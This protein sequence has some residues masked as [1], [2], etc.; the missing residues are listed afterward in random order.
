MFIAEPD[1]QDAL[2]PKLEERFGKTIYVAGTLRNFLE[3]MDSRVSKGQGLRFAL[4]RR[5][6]KPEQVIAFGDEENDIPMFEAA[7]FSA[8]PSSAKETVR[9]RA[10]LVIGPNTEDGVAAFLEEFFGL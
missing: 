2:R 6:L 5:G 9:A 8:A 1:V 3:I 7:G 10:N 4:E